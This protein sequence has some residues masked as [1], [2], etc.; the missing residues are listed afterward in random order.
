LCHSLVYFKSL[1]YSFGSIVRRMRTEEPGSPDI[2]QVKELAPLIAGAPTCIVGAG[3]HG[4]RAGGG[5]G[6]SHGFSLRKAPFINTINGVALVLCEQLIQNRSTHSEDMPFVFHHLRPYF[7]VYFSTGPW[8]KNSRHIDI[9]LA[10]SC[11]IQSTFS[12]TKIL[13]SAL[14][15]SWRTHA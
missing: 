13:S 8:R 3:V 11:I 4:T 1:E 12:T 9:I 7:F 10:T 6:S 15:T 14:D 2:L 5:R